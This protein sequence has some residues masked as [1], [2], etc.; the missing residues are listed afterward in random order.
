FFRGSG[1]GHA[2][3]AALVLAIGCSI[4]FA[5]S[6]AGSIQGTITDSTGAVIP[7]ASIK[8][9]NSATGVVSNTKSN[10]VGFYQA[11][12][13]FAGTYVVTVTATEM[14]TIQRTIV[15]LVGQ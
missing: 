6:G 2:L 9:V 15:L 5:Q 1:A 14:Q 10:G 3:S 11:P 13:F 12:G 8:V 4:A 7:G